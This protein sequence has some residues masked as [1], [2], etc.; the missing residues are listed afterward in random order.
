MSCRT[1]S[2]ATLVELLVVIAIIASML[3]ILLPG[4]QAVRKA[5]EKTEHLNW[6]RQRRLDEAPPQKTMKVV[7]IGNSRTYWNDIPG[8]VVE[9]GRSA[10]IQIHTKV[11]VEGGQT[12]EGHWNKGEAQN[13]I[14]DDWAHFVVLQEQGGR[15]TS[16][17]EF[18]LYDSYA[19]RFIQLCKTDAVPLLYATWGFKG[20]SDTTQAAITQGAFEIAKAEPNTNSEVCVVGEAWQRCYAE[21]PD[22]NLF[23][24]DRHPN[25][26][27][28]YL[29]ACVFHATL[30]R[31]SPEGLP[32]TLTTQAGTPISVDAASAHYF[33]SLA[34]EVSQKFR[35]RN[36]PYYLQKR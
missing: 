4:V 31:L 13:A 1:K 18:P 19:T 8:I 35:E 26:Y 11:V 24:D 33:Q 32:N 5:A 28:A 15:A 14:T 27:G 7:F 23:D 6:L 10:G 3:G 22:L 2:G 12:L 9:F 36:K 30:H 29:S 21:K 17:A 25:P 20:D 16:A 34:W